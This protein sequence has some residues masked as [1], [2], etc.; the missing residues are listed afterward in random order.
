M[1]YR[2][3]GYSKRFLRSTT[4]SDKK[5][6]KKKSHMSLFHA[7]KLFSL[8]LLVFA[9]IIAFI[10]FSS[11]GMYNPYLLILVSVILAAGTTAIQYVGRIKNNA[12]DFVDGKEF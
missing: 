10:D 12:D 7:I 5:S 2:K 3:V 8:Y 4:M 6:H 1:I 11:A 9:S